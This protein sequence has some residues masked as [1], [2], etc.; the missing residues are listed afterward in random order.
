MSAADAQWQRKPRIGNNSRNQS[1]S[2]FYNHQGPHACNDAKERFFTNSSIAEAE[3]Q[4]A[5]VKKEAQKAQRAR[6]LEHRRERDALRWEKMEDEQKQESAKLEWK[7]ARTRCGQHGKAYNPITLA[8]HDSN[9]GA[10]LMTEDLK[11]VHRTA[12][13]A[14]KAYFKNNS[15]NPVFHTHSFSR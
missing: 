10:D 5:L 15:F 9:H 2:V 4:R 6:I 7:Q 1:S 11:S 8:Y 12:V 13:R 3:H 14:S